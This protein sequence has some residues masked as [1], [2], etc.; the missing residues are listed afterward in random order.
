MNVPQA[1][2]FVSRAAFSLLRSIAST[3]AVSAPSRNAAPGRPANGRPD[4]FQD[5]RI[6]TIIV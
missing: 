2:R 4:P 5:S 1:G 3:A 6:W